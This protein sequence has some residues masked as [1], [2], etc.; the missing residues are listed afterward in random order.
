VVITPDE[1]RAQGSTFEWQGQRVFYRA[2]GAGEV[3][4]AVHGFPTA[5]WDWW[6]IWPH[7]TRHYRVLALDMIGFGFSAKPFGFPYSIFPQADVCE[8]LLAR[9]NVTRYRLLAHDYG[10]TVAQEL[11]ARQSGARA[12]IVAACLLNGG[13]FPELHRPLLTQKLLASPLGSL[14][15]RLSSFKTFAQSM[16]RIWGGP[17]D[18]TELRAMWQLVTHDDGLAVMPKLIG[19]IEERRRYRARWVGALIE[20]RMPLRF[21]NGL[22]DPISGAHMAARYRELVPNPD[23]ALL[24]GIGHYP[25]LEAPDA[26]ADAI[27]QNWK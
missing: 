5:S 18:D 11:L 8:A 16:R 12:K 15:A 19:Y 23:V 21:I 7:L 2:E 4:L 9:E 13:V 3:V 14:V 25:Q 27:L 1:W 10:D 17:V 24:R 22:A 20:A 6:A 26:V